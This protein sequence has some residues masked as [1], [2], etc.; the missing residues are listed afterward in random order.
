MD[1]QDR[2]WPLVVSDEAYNKRSKLLHNNKEF[3]NE[4]AYQSWQQGKI[5]DSEM[6]YKIS[7]Q[8]VREVYMHLT[9]I[10]HENKNLVDQEKKSMFSYSC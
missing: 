1:K 4:E 5:S 10:I 7:S 2:S 6:A 9:I 3:I 8:I